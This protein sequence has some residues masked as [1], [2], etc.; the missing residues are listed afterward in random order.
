MFFK[1]ILASTNGTNK[2]ILLEKE[3]V[4]PRPKPVRRKKGEP[5][6]EKKRSKGPNEPS[7][8]I[9]GVLLQKFNTGDDRPLRI[10][11]KDGTPILETVSSHTRHVSHKHDS[12]CIAAP[13]HC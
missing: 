5:A 8:S 12:V 11:G 1:R 6:P 4:P 3:V 13:A 9:I 2:L 7:A 10:K